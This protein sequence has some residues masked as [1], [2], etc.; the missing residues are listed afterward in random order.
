MITLAEKW[1]K[2]RQPN[3]GETQDKRVQ[4]VTDSGRNI[5]AYSDD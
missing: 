5:Y 4:I 2:E 3:K 1:N